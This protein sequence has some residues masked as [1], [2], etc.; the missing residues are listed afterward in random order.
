MRKT[1]GLGK[2]RTSLAAGAPTSLELGAPGASGDGSPRPLDSRVVP[3][4]DLLAEFIAEALWREWSGPATNASD[5]AAAAGPDGAPEAV[6]T[7]S[8]DPPGNPGPI[9]TVPDDSR[10][11]SHDIPS[12]HNATPQR[13]PKEDTT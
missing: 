9:P 6:G 8:D 11:L 7:L 12:N 1:N 5:P 4:L 3:L 13:H 2:R 10:R